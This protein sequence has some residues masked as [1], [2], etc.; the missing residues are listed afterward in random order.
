MN[1]K[2]AY[3]WIMNMHKFCDACNHAEAYRISSGDLVKRQSA[4]L[5]YRRSQVQ[6]MIRPDFSKIMNF[7]LY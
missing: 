7:F 4:G 3:G 1:H 2:Y 6:T 5:L